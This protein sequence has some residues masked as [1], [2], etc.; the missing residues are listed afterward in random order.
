MS[1]T[2]QE[3]TELT[4]KAIQANIALITNLNK[5]FELKN[6]LVQAGF[7]SFLP[8]EKLVDN[9]E[10]TDTMLATTQRVTSLLQGTTN[11]EPGSNQPSERASDNDG[12]NS[13]ATSPL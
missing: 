1:L 11:V 8:F 5:I 7:D 13:G 10:L 12:S 3:A 9:K 4:H 6:R 2:K